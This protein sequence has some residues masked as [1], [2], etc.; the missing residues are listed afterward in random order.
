MLGEVA[1]DAKKGFKQR[2]GRKLVDSRAIRV[3]GGDQAPLPLR[4]RQDVD[5]GAQSV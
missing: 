4:G 1:V 2:V 5:C 3:W